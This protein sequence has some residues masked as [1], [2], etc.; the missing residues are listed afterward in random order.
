MA[1][2]SST[3]DFH[4]HLPF[5]PNNF[6]RALHLT[7]AITITIFI[8]VTI[9][10]AITIAINRCCSIY[11]SVVSLQ[12][13][14]RPPPSLKAP[15]RSTA[16]AMNRCAHSCRLQGV[17]VCV[18]V[19]VEALT[20]MVNS[21]FNSWSA[22]VSGSIVTQC[23]VLLTTVA[24][25]FGYTSLPSQKG[26]AASDLFAL[27]ATEHHTLTYTLTHTL[28]YTQSTWVTCLPEGGQQLEGNMFY[29]IRDGV[30]G[31]VWWGI[32]CGYALSTCV[33]CII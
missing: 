17:C 3:V 9:T 13:T 5:I 31:C 2:H 25:C 23:V 11:V 33:W 30:C 20:G 21:Q 16:T 10:I 32:M 19:C 24:P 15:G 6:C 26:F 8:I 28:T 27:L 7:I 4:P 14:E 29:S 18:C 22:E 12:M 1:F